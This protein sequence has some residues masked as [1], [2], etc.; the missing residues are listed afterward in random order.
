MS[1]LNYWV[2]SN[3]ALIGVD[4]Q[5]QTPDGSYVE[6]SKLALLPHS[7][8]VIACRGQVA[9]LHQLYRGTFGGPPPQEYAQVSDWLSREVDAAFDGLV[10]AGVDHGIPEAAIRV[11]TEIV[12]VGWSRKVNR[13]AATRFRRE[14]I[15]CRFDVDNAETSLA[16]NAGWSKA[17]LPDSAQAHVQI[18]RDQVAFTRR[19]FPGAPIGG[20]LLLAELSKDTASLRAICKL[21]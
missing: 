17:Q 15:Q 5:A 8:V 9:L 2:S 16:P 19:N 18:A 11:D 20:R 10:A 6:T 13:M 1:L 7:N 4:T 12:T 21:G 14:A 3:K